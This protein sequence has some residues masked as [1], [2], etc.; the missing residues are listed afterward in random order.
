MV[1]YRPHPGAGAD[2]SGVSGADRV[3][4][5]PAG[6]SSRRNALSRAESVKARHARR[7]IELLELLDASSHG[8]TVAEI[9]EHFDWPQSSTSELVSLLLSMGA[10]YRTQDRRRYRTAARMAWLGMANQPAVVRTGQLQ[11]EMDALARETGYTTAIIGRVGLDAQVLGCARGDGR[12]ATIVHPGARAPLHES[13]AGWL[14]LSALGDDVWPAL[15]RR[16]R[17]EARLDHAPS[18][19]NL[20]RRVQACAPLR[21]L[22]GPAGLAPGAQMCAALVP[23]MT[24]GQPLVLAAVLAESSWARV[25][26]ATRIEALVKRLDVPSEIV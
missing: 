21:A 3:E 23:G 25:D 13:I 17:A 12:G 20:G 26:L 5:A 15:L 11:W 24:S 14:L 18:L 2:A 22:R 4:A 1:A 19:E 8:S 6:P 16:L 7:A 10:I 9:C